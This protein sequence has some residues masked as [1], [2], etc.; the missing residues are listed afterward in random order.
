MTDNPIGSATCAPAGTVDT[1]SDLEA[2][3]CGLRDGTVSEA[4]AAL[5]IERLMD[6]RAEAKLQAAG[7]RGSTVERYIMSA[8]AHLSEAPTNWCATRNRYQQARRGGDW[9]SDLWWVALPVL[10]RHQTTVF[11]LVTKDPIDAELR[12]KAPIYFAVSCAMVVLQC[13][14]AIAVCYS[15]ILQS[16]K[17]SDQ[18]PDGLYCQIGFSERCQFCGSNAPLYMQVDADGGVLNSI[19]HPRFKGFNR[20]YVAEVCADPW[21]TSCPIVCPQGSTRIMDPKGNVCD[22]MCDNFAAGGEGEKWSGGP[23]R[24]M[25]RMGFSNNGNWNLAYSSTRIREWC[26][27]CVS[28][29]TWDVDTLTQPGLLDANVESM[30][31]S[32]WAALLFAAL[33]VGFDVVG[34]LKDVHVC[35]LAANRASKEVLSP[36]WRVA[37]Q[38]LNLFRRWIFLTAL[39]LAV[40]LLV[41]FKG[42]DALS[43][44]SVESFSWSCPPLYSSDKGL[45]RWSRHLFQHDSNIV[46]DRGG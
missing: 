44:I 8:M 21:I 19:F 11:A 9:I 42:G 45:V 6:S 39:T 5:T 36:V 23:P 27:Y 41:V 1:R 33:I 10:R 28:A 14:T 13:L 18:C 30:S 34:E 37:L 12:R 4:E 24:E 22:Q 32:D 3:L 29:T 25:L 2:A 20:S 40:P 43:T 35:S 15:T 31:P 46:H 16:C 26:D 17:T 38:A 7:V